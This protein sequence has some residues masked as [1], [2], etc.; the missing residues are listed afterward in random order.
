MD[1]DPNSMTLR[2]VLTDIVIPRL[3]SIDNKVDTRMASFDRWRSRVNGIMVI[4]TPLAVAAL[5]TN[6]IH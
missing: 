4:A 1:S 2:E 6:L 5:I 3:E